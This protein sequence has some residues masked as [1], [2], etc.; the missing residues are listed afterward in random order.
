MILRVS[1]S[2]D[3]ED[4][5]SSIINWVFLTLSAGDETDAAGRQASAV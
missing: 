1:H 2:S 5:S 3:F 4:K